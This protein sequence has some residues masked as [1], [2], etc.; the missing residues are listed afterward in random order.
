M[1]NINIIPGDQTVSSEDV[2][3]METGQSESCG[4]SREIKTS[5]LERHLAADFF[6][7]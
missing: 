7:N 4:L 6:F 5:C 1:L 3:P 2:V